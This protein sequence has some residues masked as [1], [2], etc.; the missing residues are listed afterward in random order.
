MKSR[1]SSFWKSFISLF[2]IYLFV[3][4]CAFA[5]FDWHLLSRY[6]QKDAGLLIAAIAGT[7]ATIA[8]ALSLWSRHDKRLHRW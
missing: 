7:A 3:I 4:P 6:F 2:F 5:L 1:T 8:L